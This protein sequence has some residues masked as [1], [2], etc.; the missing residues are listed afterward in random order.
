LLAFTL[1]IDRR[2]QLGIG[3]QK[4]ARKKPVCDGPRRREYN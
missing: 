3:L 2:G 1:V 4:V